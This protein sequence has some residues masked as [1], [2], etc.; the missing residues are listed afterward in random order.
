MREARAGKTQRLTGEA[1]EA[2]PQREVLAFNL[3]HRQLPYCVLLRWKMPLIDTGLVRVIVRDAQGGEQG[4]E[5]QEQ[6]ILPGAHHIGQYSPD[7]MIQR[8]PEPPLGR[9]GPDE[10]PPFIH[11]GGAPWM[12][13][14]GADA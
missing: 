13:A 14:D 3:L 11:F 12:D 6:R 1:F 5:F 4:L 10:T 2:R 9:F 7:V 8:M